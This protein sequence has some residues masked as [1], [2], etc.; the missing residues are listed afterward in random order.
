MKGASVV[1]IFWDLS[2]SLMLMNV[3]LFECLLSDEPAAGRLSRCR[4]TT[5]DAPTRARPN[6]RTTDTDRPSASDATRLIAFAAAPEPNENKRQLFTACDY[7]RTQTNHI[8]SL[9]V[10]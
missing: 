1:V 5:D 10:S 2:Q 9:E 6:D 8:E 3:Q 7:V 4:S